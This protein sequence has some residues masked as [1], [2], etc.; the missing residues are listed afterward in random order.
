ML[1][2]ITSKINFQLQELLTLKDI[3]DALSQM[4]PTKAPGPE[5]LPA[6]F[7]Q[8][9]LQTVHSSVVKTC[10]HIL[11]EQDNPVPLNHT[12]ITLIP[13]TAKPRKV[14][15]YRPIN[16]CNVVYRIVAKAIANRMK[17]LIS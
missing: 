13:K 4:C 5:S 8:K 16:L 6:A 9:H 14:I 12:Y 17:P 1:P 10:L 3:A 7:F 2:K 15:D 11:D